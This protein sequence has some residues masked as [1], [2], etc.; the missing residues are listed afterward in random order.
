M[1]ADVRLTVNQ[2]W[3]TESKQYPT[4]VHN[5]LT[6]N[7]EHLTGKCKYPTVKCLCLT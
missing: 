3:L 7:I 1:D 6:Q 4:E 2:V 5:L